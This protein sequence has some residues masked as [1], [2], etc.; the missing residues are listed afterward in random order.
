MIGIRDHVEQDFDEQHGLS[1]YVYMC[2]ESYLG[3]STSY[4]IGTIAA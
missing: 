2:T 4:P 3:I 1:G